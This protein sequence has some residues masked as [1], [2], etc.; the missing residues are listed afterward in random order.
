M[1]CCCPCA[2]LRRAKFVWTLYYLSCFPISISSSSYYRME[3]EKSRN[4][5]VY[6]KEFF[7]VAIRC[8]LFVGTIILIGKENPVCLNI[9]WFLSEVFYEVLPSMCAR[10]ADLRSSIIYKPT[11]RDWW[12]KFPSYNSGKS[13][14][15]QAPSLATKHKCTEIG[16]KVMLRYYWV[17]ENVIKCINPLVVPVKR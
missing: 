1:K 8:A 9:I 2:L 15:P 4:M 11:S 17:I 14:R 10:C 12:A 13:S 5:G 7:W 16:Y 3:N 6:G